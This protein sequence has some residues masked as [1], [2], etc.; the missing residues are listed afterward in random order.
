MACRITWLRYPCSTIV[1]ASGPSAVSIS[2]PDRAR[3]SVI[4]GARRGRSGRRDEWRSIVYIPAR[5]RW[6]ISSAVIASWSDDQPA[7]PSATRRS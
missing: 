4:A 6:T 5:S 2:R 7:A 3:S 1:T